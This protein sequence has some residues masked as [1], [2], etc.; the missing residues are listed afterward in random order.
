MKKALSLI[1]VFCVLLTLTACGSGTAVYVQSVKTLASLG[2]IAPG[3][4]FVGLVVSEN[5]TE[6]EKDAEKTI[7]NLNVKA[8][9]DVKEGQELFS[10]DT[11]ELQLTLDKQRLE[12]EQLKASIE[13]YKKQITQLEKERKN[14][15]ATQKL[16]YTVHIQTTQVDL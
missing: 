6:I 15:N 12:L 13:S 4:R 9:D 5:V 2:G 14:E 16:Q 8:G 3:D 11:E 1:L 7:L 10:Y